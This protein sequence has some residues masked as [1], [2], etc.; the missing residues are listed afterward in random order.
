MKK[1]FFMVCSLV[2]LIFSISMVALGAGNTYT[3]SSYSFKHQLWIKGGSKLKTDTT[4]KLT[5]TD[6]SS[7]SNSRKYMLVYEVVWENPDG[8][9][10]TNGGGKEF[11]RGKTTTKTWTYNSTAERY[12][13]G[14]LMT[15]YGITSSKT[16][17]N[18]FK[19]R[20]KLVY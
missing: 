5:L 12:G 13:A 17:T 18:S 2:V 14:F 19:G 11:Y 7:S 8:S 9:Y 16:V 6:T 3:I 1:R 10:V 15:A 4:P 20:G